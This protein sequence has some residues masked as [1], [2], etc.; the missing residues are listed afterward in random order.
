[1]TTVGE[2]AKGILIFFCGYY[3]VIALGQAVSGQTAI[4]ALMFVG[5]LIPLSIVVH[6]Y[7]KDKRA[8]KSSKLSA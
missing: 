8:H 6:G 5:F 2:I 4:A 7:V 1:M 3:L